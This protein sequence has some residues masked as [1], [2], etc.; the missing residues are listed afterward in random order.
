MDGGATWSGP[1]D[2]G[3]SASSRFISLGEGTWIATGEEYV[4]SVD[5]GLTWTAPAS[6]S[7]LVPVGIGDVYGVGTIIS[8][9]RSDETLAVLG[10]KTKEG[11]HLERR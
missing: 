4:V 10:M 8:A 5:D 3:L 11:T 7:S 6:T 2:L 1:V 9:V